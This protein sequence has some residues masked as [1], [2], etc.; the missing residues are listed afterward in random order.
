M[1]LTFVSQGKLLITGEY[2]VLEGAMAF[3][4]PTK[5]GQTMEVELLPGS[6]NIHW[7]AKDFQGQLWLNCSFILQDD[8]LIPVAMSTLANSPEVKA[9][10][11]LLENALKLNP[12]YINN[13]TDYEITCQ[14]EFPR[15]WGLGSSSTLVANIAKWAGVNAMD[16]FFISWE[17]SGYDVAQAL[18]TMPICYSLNNKKP[19]WKVV[20]FNKQFNDQIY[21][22]WLG[23][24]QNSRDAITQYKLHSKK[25]MSEI[26]TISIITNK[27]IACDNIIEFENLIEQH[28]SIV[29]KILGV[30]PI[31]SRLFSDYNGTIKSLGA[32]G[33]DFILVT[34]KNAETYFTAK[35]YQVILPFDKMILQ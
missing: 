33:G 2:L 32:W 6:G 7:M 23:V 3:S 16:L 1:K 18:E 13:Q 29:S 30:E 17:G 27:I 28:E 34:G 14:L 26:E 21:F 11:D 12:K 10:T 31:K 22:V 20:Q 19:T 4:L 5:F 9:L 25:Q 8:H 15:D 24:K 35:G